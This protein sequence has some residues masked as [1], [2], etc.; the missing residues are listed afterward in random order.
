M[1]SHKN[2]ADFLA[3]GLLDLVKIAQETDDGYLQKWVVSAAGL[4]LRI[5][6]RNHTTIYLPDFGN[7]LG[8]PL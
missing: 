7:E 4:V 2:F 3:D 5:G 8:K 1:N 6:T